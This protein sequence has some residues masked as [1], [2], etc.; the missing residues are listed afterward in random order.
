MDLELLSWYSKSI[1][2]QVEA[3]VCKVWK[4]LDNLWLCELWGDVCSI[5]QVQ[6][7]NAETGNGSVMILTIFC[8]VS[9]RA[10]LETIDIIWTLQLSSIGHN[11]TWMGDR[12]G[13]ASAIS[14]VIDAAKRQI[15]SFTSGYHHWLWYVILAS[16]SGRASANSTANTSG[17]QKSNFYVVK[18][19][20]QLGWVWCNQL[21]RNLT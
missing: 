15:D 9:S 21:F 13:A 2:S 14:L 12:L 5:L 7:I 10:M 8:N 20:C 3:C 19:T 18:R 1:W 17:K 4:R 16:V 6:F 11:S